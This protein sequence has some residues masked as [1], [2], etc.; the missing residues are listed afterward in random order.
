MFGFDN[1]LNFEENLQ[2]EDQEFPAVQTT[3][4]EYL[5]TGIEIGSEMYEGI[6]TSYKMKEVN[7]WRRLPK[8]PNFVS[9]LA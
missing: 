5:S 2:E 3:R 1:Q 4:V 7:N 9:G 6:K 8:L